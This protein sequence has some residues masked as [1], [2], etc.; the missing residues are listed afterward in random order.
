MF[1]KILAITKSKRQ[2]NKC[3][4]IFFNFF[5]PVFLMMG[6]LFFAE[7]SVARETITWVNENFPPAFILDGPDKGNGIT[8]GA[9]S[10]YKKYLPEYN[11]RHLIA[12]MTRI[13]ELMKTG[14][15]V[16]YA[17]FIKT[18]EREKYIQ[19]SLPNIITYANTIIAKKDSI[20]L[21]FGT[22][23]SA[24][25][26][27][28]LKKDKLKLGLTHGRAYGGVI[29]QLLSTYAGTNKNI[30]FRSGQNELLGLLEM[31]D[32]KRI[33]YTIGYPW[34]VAYLANQINKRNQYSV[35]S[36]RETEGQQW[37]LSYAG[38]PKNEWGKKFIQKLNAVLIKVRPKEDYI[39]HLLKWYPPEIETD[40]R[41]A[42]QQMVLSVNE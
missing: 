39:H 7:L 22:K 2:K 42:Y 20:N 34:E 13:L 36:I 24:S 28:L 9:V 16:C 25:L 19:F 3:I 4:S 30:F 35:I 27:T 17:G 31:M 12:N 23:K 32:H 26:K 38:C 21:L 29:D 15:K 6:F 11:H 18:T 14:K 40:I 8:D 41:Q 5:I 33:D 37:V 10:V 1:L